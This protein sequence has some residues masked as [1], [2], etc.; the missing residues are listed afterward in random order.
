M[1]A[2]PGRLSCRCMLCAG[3][4]AEQAALLGGMLYTRPGTGTPWGRAASASASGASPFR[5]SW[6][7]TGMLTGFGRTEL[8]RA[9]WRRRH[10]RAISG[11]DRH[12]ERIAGRAQPDARQAVGQQRGH[13]VVHGLRSRAWNPSY[14]GLSGRGTLASLQACAL[15]QHC[16]L[17]VHCQ[18]IYMD[19]QGS[20]FSDMPYLQKV[21]LSLCP[22]GTGLH[23]NTARHAACLSSRQQAACRQ[24]SLD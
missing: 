19:M 10:R 16:H 11:A 3:C 24:G 21:L 14:Q 4:S 7:Q 5:A 15:M 9:S 8:R 17:I 20:Y 1:P 6:L 22:H 18:V 13:L 2:Q 23:G 12:G